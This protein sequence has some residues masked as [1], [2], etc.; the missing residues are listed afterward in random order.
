MAVLCH[1][2]F[3]YAGRAAVSSESCFVAAISINT[4]EK[5]YHLIWSTIGLPYDCLYLRNVPRPIGGLLVFSTC[6]IIHVVQ[7]SPP[8]GI[9]LNSA[10][11]GAVRFTLKPV[12]NLVATLDGSRCSFF[13]SER[14]LLAL[15]NGNVYVITLIHDSAVRSIKDFHFQQVLNSRYASCITPLEGNEK[16]FS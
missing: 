2:S 11:V 15:R 6:S 8:I 10:A 14:C 1:K 16:Q 7:G 4:R 12:Q 3:S 13:E 5:S 9:S